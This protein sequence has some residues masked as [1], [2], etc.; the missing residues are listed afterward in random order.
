MSTPPAVFRALVEAIP[1][2]EDAAFIAKA[3]QRGRITSR[4]GNVDMG[5][6]ALT[7]AA[8]DK[9]AAT[10]FPADQLRALEQTGLAQLD[11]VLPGI[12]GT[13]TALAGSTPTDR[14]LDIRRRSTGAA[15]ADVRP[16]AEASAEPPAASGFSD[17]FS[18]RADLAGLEFPPRRATDT[19]LT[20]LAMPDDLFERP[21]SGAPTDLFPLTVPDDIFDRPAGGGVSESWDGGRRPTD[22]REI[23]AGDSGR[24]R[25]VSGRRRAAR[26]MFRVGLPVAVCLAAA[27]AVAGYF[28]VLP[29]PSASRTT[30]SPPLPPAGTPPPPARASVPPPASPAPLQQTSNAAPQVTAPSQTAP[31]TAPAAQTTP[32][33]AATSSAPAATPS[34]TA[35][36]NAATAPVIPG[37]AAPTVLAAPVSSSQTAA[38]STPAAQPIRSQEPA[39]RGFSVQVAAVRTRDEA[40][41]LVTRL[42]SQGYPAYI[43]RGE[44]AAANFYRVR[45]GA[46]PSRESA[47]KIAKQLEGTEGIKPWIM[48]EIPEN[49]IP[50]S[51]LPVPKEHPNRR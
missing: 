31:S 33:Q 8:I 43:V 45:I 24:T 35:P 6:M 12:D 10:I 25:A 19:D 29:L 2:G 5:S 39:R 34:Q 49:N 15:P 50:A 3:G 13:F 38:S 26:G 37:P 48:K 27:L 14:W 30:A 44:G 17:G 22:T 40:D 4:A 47:E 28:G 51:P 42:V 18:D 46:F 16:A 9:L 21:E 1:A 23:F 32:S 36:S 11:F 41:R 20:S 7:V